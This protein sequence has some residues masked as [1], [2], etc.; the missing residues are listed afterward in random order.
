VLTLGDGLGDLDGDVGVVDA[1]PVAVVLNLEALLPEV[2]GQP[3][4]AA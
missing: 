3:I 4:R 2:G 1:G